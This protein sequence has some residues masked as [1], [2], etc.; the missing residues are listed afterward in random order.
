M[1]PTLDVHD[2]ASSYI[3]DIIQ[4]TIDRNRTTLQ[5]TTVV[6][7]LPLTLIGTLAF[8]VSG[9]IAGVR[10][11]L[12]WFGVVVLAV[13]VALSGG[14][15]RDVLLDHEPVTL[16]EW[17]YLAAALGA[18]IICLVAHRVLESVWDFV[19][20]FDALGL[21]TFSVVGT[22]IALASG[23]GV[24]Q[25]VALGTISGIGGGVFRDVLLGQIPVVLREDLYAIPALLGATVVAAASRF[26]ESAEV[27]SWAGVL[28]C[29]LPRLISIR[30]PIKMPS[31]L[32]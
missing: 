13:V 10:A 21:A 17:R 28:A 4:S 29:L 3:A 18:G 26:G 22:T 23:L 24:P 25:A 7:E 8:G 14:I 9:G 1:R 20:V 32:R 31:T 2:Y 30:W 16:Q 27:W 11:Q 12:D 6:D 15:V 19:L 5:R